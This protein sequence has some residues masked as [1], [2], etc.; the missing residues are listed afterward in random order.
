MSDLEAVKVINKIRV[1]DMMK[2]ASLSVKNALVIIQM[3][4]FTKH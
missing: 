1:A 4:N 2:F 3:R